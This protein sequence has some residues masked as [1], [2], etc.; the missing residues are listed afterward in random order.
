MKTEG[1]IMKRIVRWWR[2]KAR[3]VNALLNWGEDEEVA[4]LTRGEVVV[5]VFGAVLFVFLPGLLE[6][7]F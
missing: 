2:E 6:L 1:R 7:V 4:D 3:R 5:C